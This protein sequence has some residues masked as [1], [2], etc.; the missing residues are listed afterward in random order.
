MRKAKKQGLVA[1]NVADD[2]D[3]TPQSDRRERTDAQIHCWSAAGSA[4]VPRGGEAA[5]PRQ[6]AFYA[7]ALDSGAR[8]GELCGVAWTAFDLDAGTM[9]ITRQLLKAGPD[10]VFGPPKNRRSRTIRLAPD[11]VTLLLALR[12]HQR[13][14][15][16]ANR[17]RYVD[18]GL[19]FTKEPADLQQLRNHKV[20]RLGDPLQA[21]NIGQREYAQLVKAADVRPIKFHGLRHTCATLLLQAREPVH[22]VSERLGHKKV[23]VTLEVYAHALP[24]M[25]AQAAST[26]NA[27]LHGP[28][29]AVSNPLAKSG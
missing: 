23:S 12:K 15:M 21:N 18:I 22:V 2:L 25:Q 28:L 1:R 13:E 29:S 11:T 8:K 3:D 20:A 27:I 17:A 9:A 10:P 26:M 5:G 24:D 7:L 4:Q 14:L 16:M 6:A 19:A